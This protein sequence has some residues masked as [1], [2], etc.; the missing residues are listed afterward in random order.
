MDSIEGTKAATAVLV[1]GIAFFLS[2]TIGANIVHQN[3]PEKPAIEIKVAS[4]AAAP[5]GTA[6]PVATG[7]AQT[8]GAGV[9]LVPEIQSV[10]VERG[11]SLWRISRRVLGR[12]VRYTQIYE[13][14]AGQIRDP[15]RIWPGQIFVAPK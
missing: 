8:L 10:T 1:A 4:E 14:N 9:A 12:G 6:A 7:A 3:K 15:N 11:D 13:A 2:G 5:A